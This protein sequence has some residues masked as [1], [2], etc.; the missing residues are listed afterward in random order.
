[1]TVV[2]LDALA[3]AL[4]QANFSSSLAFPQFYCDRVKNLPWFSLLQ[5]QQ[6]KNSRSLTFYLPTTVGNNYSKLLSQTFSKSKKWYSL[7][8]FV[9][10]YNSLH[11]WLC[12]LSPRGHNSRP[13]ILY[14][15]GTFFPFG[16]GISLLILEFLKAAEQ[17]FNTVNRLSWA[18][19]L[20]PWQ[21]WSAG[22]QKCSAGWGLSLTRHPWLPYPSTSGGTQDAAGWNSIN[23]WWSAVY[24]LS[25]HFP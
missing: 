22:S 3:K 24:P 9:V 5:K 12:G 7:P 23:V 11:S 10:G 20:I 21:E 19:H 17:A 18:S 25:L 14:T 1:M 4:A 15:P 13:P 6:R 16:D 2:G 8:K